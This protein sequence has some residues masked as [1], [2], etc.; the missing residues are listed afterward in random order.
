MSSIDN[1]A[2]KVSVSLA[3]YWKWVEN[4]R[5]PGKYPPPEAIRRW[6]E[7]KP[8]NISPINGRMPSVEQVGFLIGRKIAEEGTEAQ[9]FFEPA[10]EQV[11]REFEE[12]I[13]YAIEEDV[14]NYILELVDERL[15]NI[16]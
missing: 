2:F 7:V 8:V 16:L 5:G 14:G 15:S 13:A 9:P 10:K 6:I 4:G 11:I 1:G 12:R 3:E